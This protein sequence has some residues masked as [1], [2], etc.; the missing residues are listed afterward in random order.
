M[1]L[2]LLLLLDSET[3]AVAA[4][5]GRALRWRWL[6]FSCCAGALESLAR[7]ETVL[8]RVEVRVTS[9]VAGR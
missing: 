5:A 8:S 2:P 6:R 3:V 4:V 1:L 9:H 7:E